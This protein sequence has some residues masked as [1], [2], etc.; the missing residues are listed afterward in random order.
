M[1]YIDALGRLAAAAGMNALVDA[2]L[3]DEDE[4]VRLACLD[5]VVSHHYKPA[6]AKYVQALKHKDNPVVNRAATGLAQL[7][8]ARAIGPLIGALVTIHTFEIQKGQP[9]QTN[10]TFT[11]GLGGGGGG[12]TFGGGGVEIRKVAFENRDVLQALVDLTGGTSF[13]FDVKSWQYWFAAQKKPA[14]LDARRDAKPQ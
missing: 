8:D 10:S 1:L 12:F 4:E 3:Y 14:S 13:N 6:V 7:K 2:S 11:N 9:G 5:Q